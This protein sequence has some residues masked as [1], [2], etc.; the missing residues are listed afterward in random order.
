MRATFGPWTTES[1]AAGERSCRRAPGLSPNGVRGS[2]VQQLRSS[3]VTLFDVCVGLDLDEH[4]AVD[5]GADL[6]H[7]CRGADIAEDFAVRAADGFPITSDIDDVDTRPND[8][9]ESGTGA[10]ER[11]TDV[12]ESLASL[13]R[14]VTDTEELS[15]GIRGGRTGDVYPLTDTYRA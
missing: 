8:L 3:A 9:I 5:E 15:V 12:R 14:G 2:V 6:D 7:R 11:A 1:A 13:S 10:R 4:L